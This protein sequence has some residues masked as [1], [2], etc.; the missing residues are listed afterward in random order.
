M[1]FLPQ[2]NHIFLCNFSFYNLQSCL[3]YL[4]VGK[5]ITICIDFFS[6]FSLT[7]SELI[8][9]FAVLD[10]IIFF[11]FSICFPYAF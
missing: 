2:V 8:L 6:L 5:F 1:Q 10:R 7:S 11:Y 3:L 4:P 9:N